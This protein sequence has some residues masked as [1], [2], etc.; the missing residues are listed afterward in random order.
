MLIFSVPEQ[1]KQPLREKDPKA[2]TVSCGHSFPKSTQTFLRNCTKGDGLELSRTQEE[3]KPLERKPT[4][5]TSDGLS[6]PTQVVRERGEVH[7]QKQPPILT[8]GSLRASRAQ[9]IQIL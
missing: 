3:G 8:M 9:G 2:E 4:S 6:W 7:N 1:I 5:Y